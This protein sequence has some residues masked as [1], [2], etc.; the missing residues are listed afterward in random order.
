[1]DGEK[2]VADQWRHHFSLRLN[3]LNLSVVDD[4]SLM[5]DCA[6][7]SV[8]ITPPRLPIDDDG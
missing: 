5:I 2:S 6:D 1:M 8:K 3:N 4:F 7:A